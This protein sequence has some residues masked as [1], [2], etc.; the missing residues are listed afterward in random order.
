MTHIGP[1][2]YDSGVQWNGVRVLVEHVCPPIPI[3]TSDYAA[4]LEDIEPPTGHVLDQPEPFYP[5]GWGA[6]KHDALAEV[7]QQ[8]IDWPED[9]PTR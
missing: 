1:D 7:L 8:L 3:R 9:D 2:L 5:Q 6:T 4:Y